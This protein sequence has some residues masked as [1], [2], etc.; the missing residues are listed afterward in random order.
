MTRNLQ[1]PVE[2]GM[3]VATYDRLVA[4]GCVS[5]ACLGRGTEVVMG[6]QTPDVTQPRFAEIL[7]F[8]KDT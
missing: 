6:V 1:V 8:G 2:S 3:L 7:N 4:A 5:V